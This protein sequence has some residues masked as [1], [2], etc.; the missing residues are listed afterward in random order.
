MFHFFPRFSR[1]VHA[2]PFAAELRRLGVP[3]ELFS[4]ELSLHYT[5]RAGL[6]LQ[7]YPKLLFCAARAAVRSLILSRT[8][9]DVVVIKS[10]VEAI[11][12]GLFRLLFSRRTR[13]VF[14]TFIAAGRG[15]PLK[16]RLQHL[17]YSVVLS[18]VDVAV[19]HSSTEAE[20]YL[21]QFPR[22]TARFAALPFGLSVDG[23][24]ALRATYDEDAAASNIVV[25]AGRS[26]RD[27]ATLAKAVAGLPCR[28]RVICDWER[29]TLAL[30]GMP[31]VTI[32]RNCFRSDYLAELARARIVV[33][34][35]SQ[36][37]ISAG[38]MVMQQ[39]FALGKP[40]VIT[41]TP[42][43]REYAADGCD[44]LLA[45]FGD[46]DDMRA[47]ISALLADPAHCAELGRR[48][49]ERY[50]LEFSTEAYVRNLVALLGDIAGNHR[51]A[52]QS[53]PTLVSAKASAG[54]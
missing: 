30:E 22:T 21:L 24:E 16:R 44:A 13:I 25:S 43:T 18:F 40:V 5:T 9:P 41:D 26:A 54:D 1:N 36:K 14:E 4:E 49:A 42:T 10:D 8:K 29:P 12:F 15:S 34:P 45:D 46:A 48:G 7:V 50:D 52:R 3:H 6:L 38:Q 19:C 37:R 53:V 2:T 47:K 31:E 23:R 39:A 32:V 28:V 35:L 33:V 27:Y 20:D 11:V 51:T 17:H